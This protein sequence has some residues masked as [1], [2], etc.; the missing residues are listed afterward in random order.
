MAYN[1][2]TS[3]VTAAK[4]KIPWIK[5]SMLGVQWIDFWEGAAG[6]IRQR[7]GWQVRIDAKAVY[8]GSS[9]LLHSDADRI[10]RRID[11]L[12]NGADHLNVKYDH[13]W[14]QAYQLA[15]RGMDVMDTAGALVNP[16]PQMQTMPCH[17]CGIILPLDAL[18]V[19]H[20]MPQAGGDD[21]YTLKM[22]R[23]MDMCTSGPTGSKGTAIFGRFGWGTIHPKGRARG[24]FGHLSTTSSPQAKWS[25]NEVGHCFLSLIQLGGGMVD[26]KRICKNSSLNLTPLCGHCNRQKS[27]QIRPIQ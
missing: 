21:L 4:K 16:K 5:S 6:V 17:N 15:N 25:T 20:Y 11:G 22:L 7:Q 1:K 12:N 3:I 27:N 24:S 19:D 9:H 26:L 8:C 10:G 2:V 14:L 18:Q 13:L 23:S